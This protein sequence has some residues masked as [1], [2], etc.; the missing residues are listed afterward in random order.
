MRND[1][2]IDIIKPA[3]TK[4]RFEHTLRVADTAA[5]LANL[6]H[7]S[8]EKVELAAI[9]HDYAKFKP[10]DE[11]KQFILDSQLPNDLLDYHH[12]VWH[13]PVAS[14]I[15][16]EQFGIKDQEISDA[17]RYHTTG[18]ANLGAM[19]MVVFLADYIEPGRSIPGVDEVRAMAREDLFHACLM[20]SRN[21]LQFLLS[22]NT[23]IYP[24]S[25]HAYNY[26]LSQLKKA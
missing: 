10:L 18:K 7:V 19:G 21:T 8:T 11:M 15:V 23:T 1:E 17:I 16:A 20:V 3:L 26:F 4:A 13:G 25:F 14:V 24:D 2:A 6:Y 12:E 22:K 5:E 9:F